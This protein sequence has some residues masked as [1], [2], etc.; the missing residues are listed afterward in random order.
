MLGSARHCAAPGAWSSARP[1]GVRLGESA[2]SVRPPAA[3]WR[4]LALLG[5]ACLPPAAASAWRCLSGRCVRSPDAA[6]LGRPAL[7]A[8]PP[9]AGGSTARP[10]LARPPDAA[11]RC[12]AWRGRPPGAVWRARPPLVARPPVPRWL[13]EAARRWLDW[14][15]GGGRLCT[16]R[17]A[18]R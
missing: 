2:A 17:R 12:A 1:P 16:G 4:G 13:G 9:G 7:V 15:D 18:G 11:W 8:R 5:G 14:R 3:A 10:P 6:W